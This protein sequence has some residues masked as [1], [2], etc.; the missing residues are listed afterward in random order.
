[1]Q[2]IS[3]VFDLLSYNKANYSYNDVLA[4]KKDSKWVKYSCEDFIKISD[5]VSKGLIRLGI[6]KDD[7]VAIM[8]ENMPEWNF[9]DFGIMQIGAAQVPMYPT[10]AENDIKF[11]FKDADIKVV[12]VSSEPLYQKLKRI[13]EENGQDIKIYTFEKIDGAP[14]WTEIIET[15]DDESFI[16]LDEY[17]S[18]ITGD[19]LLT[20]IYTSGTTGTPKGVML[21]HKNLLSNIEAS[22][23]LYPEGVTRALSFLPLSHIFE[24]MVVYMYFYLGISV[25]YAESL[26]TIVQNLSEVKPHCFTSVPRLLEKVYD[27]IV[28]K[29]HEL[30]GIKKSLFFWALNLGLKY[31]LDGANGAWYELQLKL[32]RKLIFK[33][34][35][36]ALGGEIMLIVSGGA[37]LQERLAR[38]FWGAGIKVLEGYGLTETSPVISVNG[39]RKGETKFGT[40]GKPL[41][42]V[43]VKIAEDGEILC[44]G[45]SLMKGYYKRDDATQ[46]AVTEGGWF[47]TGDIG[48]LKDG[49]LTITDRKKEVFKTAGGKYVAPQVL[50]TKFKESTFI[51]QVMV[52]GENRRFPSALIVPN[53][54][55]V[56][57]WAKRNQIAE[58][59]HQKLAKNQKVIDK[60]W[61]EVDRLN[62]D[63]GKWEKVKKIA[64]LPHEFTIDG[65]EL[66]PKLSLRRKVILK[67]N[68]AAIEEI[69]KDEEHHDI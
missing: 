29:G 33:K 53:F 32:A 35:K 8:A 39:P 51:E 10:L 19:D 61:S 66:T 12:F 30:T 27:K 69:Y 31:E 23:K 14:H 43:E 59:D 2:G 1:M 28:A 54:E 17:R 62:A 18:K 9:C 52:L 65:G 5:Q 55:K 56:I 60:I 26:D 50:E 49:F 64:L 25:Y 36:D 44:K 15:H 57:E 47:H 67:N 48:N 68:E 58:T 41:F 38:V 6:K 7:K 45:P 4:Y 20:L 42:N 34:W 11:I 16:D 13:A 3:R 63:F 21:T 37:A 24:R 22:A 40:V 46:E